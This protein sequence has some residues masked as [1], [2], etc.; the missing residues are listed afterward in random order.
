MPREKHV[1]TTIKKAR[2]LDVVRA[3]MVF[4]A[5][6]RKGAVRDSVRVWFDKFSVG[7]ERF[8]FRG[9][10][11]YWHSEIGVWGAFNDPTG[12]QGLPNY[13]NPFG[14]IPRS[15]MV[16]EINPPRGGINTNVQGII[17]INSRGQRWILHQGRL[18]PS[19]LRITEEM[20]DGV[21]NRDRVNVRFSNGRLVGYH[22]VA[23]ID[24]EPSE[25]KAQ[26]ASFVSEC[27]TV[28][29]YYLVGPVV[30]KALNSIAVIEGLFP[31]MRGSYEVGSQEAKTVV[32]KHP[33]VWHR[34]SQELVAK[35]I[36]YSNGRVRRWG[37]DLLTLSKRPILFE[38][39]SSESASEL[40]RAVGQLLLYEKFLDAPHL[41]VLVYPQSEKSTD[42]LKAALQELDVH[43]LPYSRKGRMIR[44]EPSLLTGFIRYAKGSELPPN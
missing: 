33:D 3:K 23:N 20:F 18:H 38:I 30:T 21:T 26:I 32:K 43:V 35:G 36:S 15:N 28:R 5:E 11:A 12:S 17:A 41:K 13:W 44:F 31:E 40:Q 4:S 24:A 22:T 8:S 29:Q 37:P 16:V 42:A 6:E 39:K 9:L 25:L 2:Q 1:E 27:E 19:K 34:L 7:A 10:N 14:R